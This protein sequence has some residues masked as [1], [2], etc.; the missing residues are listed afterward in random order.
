[1]TTTI[2]E[3]T[4]QE[5]W[6]GLARAKDSVLVDVRTR[7]EWTFVGT[8][9]LSAIGKSPI[10]LEWVVWPGMQLN[11]EFI[12]QLMAQLDG[13]APSEIYFLCRSGGRSMAAAKAVAAALAAQGRTTRCINVAEGF[14][15][16]LDQARH[17]GT[18]NGWKA[19]GL[20]WLQS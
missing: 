18:M 14:E 19:R 5:A 8:P 20:P 17:R 6:D 16:D 9:D 11:E 13:S 2:S 3:V 10:L 4:P 1:M 12:P 7:A 15:G